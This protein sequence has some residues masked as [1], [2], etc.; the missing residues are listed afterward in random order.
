[1]PCATKLLNQPHAYR[2]SAPSK[3]LPLLAT[4][5][6]SRRACQPPAACLRQWQYCDTLKSSRGSRTKQLWMHIHSNGLQCPARP[7][8]PNRLG[9]DERL[10]WLQACLGQQ[11]SSGRRAIHRE[12]CKGGRGSAGKPS[13]LAWWQAQHALRGLLNHDQ[14]LGHHNSGAAHPPSAI[15]EPSELWPPTSAQP[16]CRSTVSAPASI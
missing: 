12:A 3:P 6:C 4:G 10:P 8:C 13:C 15:S 1:M 14:N 7:T 16:A 9:Q 11:L 5:P 2:C